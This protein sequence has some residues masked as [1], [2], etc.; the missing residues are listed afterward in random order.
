M[1]WTKGIQHFTG[2]LVKDA[3]PKDAILEITTNKMNGPV[4]FCLDK[5]FM[6][7]KVFYLVQGGQIVGQLLANKFK[8]VYQVDSVYIDPSLRGM[9]LAPA[10]YKAISDVTGTTL[11]SGDQLSK[12]AE[13]LWKKLEHF[14]RTHI[15]DAK[16]QEFYDL[17]RVGSKTEDGEEIVHPS[18][19]AGLKPRFHL[20]LM[21]SGKDTSKKLHERLVQEQPY[22]HGKTKLDA[23]FDAGVTYPR[24]VYAPLDNLL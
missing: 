15:Y 12:D 13:K 17:D 11:I 9:N 22:L 4:L 2:Y 14:S 8:K 20:A 24:V 23:L 19:S 3:D 21:S 7:S 18:L 16:L 1:E 10:L 6:P 5:S